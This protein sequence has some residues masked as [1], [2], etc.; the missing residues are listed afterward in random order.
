VIEDVDCV[1]TSYP[2]FAETLR[3]LGADLCEVEA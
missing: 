3:A 1:R 2:S